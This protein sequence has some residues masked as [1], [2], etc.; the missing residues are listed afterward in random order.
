MKKIIILFLIAIILSGCAGQ[1]AASAPTAA[2]TQS[3][4][5]AANGVSLNLTVMAP[6]MVVENIAAEPLSAGGMNLDP[7]P[8]YRRVTMRDYP[9]TGSDRQPQI[10]IFPVA[11][12][13]GFNDA[14][15][16]EMGKLQA[17]LTAKTPS[18]PM[19]F[20]P[21]INAKQVMHPQVRFMDFKNGQGVRFLT[22]YSQGLVRVSSENLFYTYQGLTRDGRYYVS[23]VLPVTHPGLP[24]KTEIFAMTEDEMK[25]Y[26][27]YLTQSNGWL[28]QQPSAS[29]SP[30][31][32]KLD[33]LMQSIEVK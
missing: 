18:D 33:S 7:S 22:W 28:E 31:L 17:L 30:N 20:L 25:G 29:F 3:P 5:T 32:E 6:S 4:E 8:T 27:N 1:A 13:A 15:G 24:E 19:P 23:A 9:V 2:P 21:L 16:Q 14:A 11:E 26:P 12:M 10:F